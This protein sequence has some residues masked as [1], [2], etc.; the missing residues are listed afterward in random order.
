MGLSDLLAKVQQYAAGLVRDGDKERLHMTRDR[1]LQINDRAALVDMWTRDGRVFQFSNPAIQTPETM[2]AAG[3]ALVLTDPSIRFTVPAGG[4]VVPI[5]VSVKVAAVVAKD[6]LFAVIASETDT[7]SSG[8]ETCTT[9]QSLIVRG[10]GAIADRA[11]IITN[12]FHS[13][14]A[15]VEAALIR[16]RLLKVIKKEGVASAVADFHFNPE[17]NILKGDP[18]VYLEGPASFLV[19]HVQETTAAEGQFTVTFAVLD[20]GSVGK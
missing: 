10:A 2:S 6:D 9:P 11:S 17:F 16:P 20:P 7:Y 14:T 19:Y 18:L 3:T 1:A 12:V 13:D 8:G 4:L 15:I 5:S